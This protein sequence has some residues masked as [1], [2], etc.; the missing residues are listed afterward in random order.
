M[1][2][3]LLQT[4]RAP[5]VKGCAEVVRLFYT[6]PNAE[7]NGIDFWYADKEFGFYEG[8]PE[9]VVNLSNTHVIVV[10]EVRSPNSQTDSNNSLPMFL[11]VYPG[12]G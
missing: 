4:P 12:T 1:D 9:R 6:F 10:V 5:P 2:R 7:G 3:F 11:F 8:L